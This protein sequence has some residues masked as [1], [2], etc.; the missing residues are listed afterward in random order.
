MQLLNIEILV[1]ALWD[2]SVLLLD[3]VIELIL[4]KGKL[5]Q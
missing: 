2:V 3:D 5:F 4:C 1:D